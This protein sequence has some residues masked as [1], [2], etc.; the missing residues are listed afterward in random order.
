ME[1]ANDGARFDSLRFYATNSLLLQPV[2]AREGTATAEVALPT[3]PAVRLDWSYALHHADGTVEIA[4]VRSYWLIDETRTVV[5]QLTTYGSEP[6]A[7]ADFESVIQA[8]HWA[9]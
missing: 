9:S 5:I 2:R 4:A 1:L 3:G 6:A 8:M 7:V